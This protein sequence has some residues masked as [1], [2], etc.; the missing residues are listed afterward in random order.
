MIGLKTLKE[1]VRALQHEIDNKRKTLIQ[2]A[3]HTYPL[4]ENIMNATIQNSGS[5]NQ[6]KIMIL[7]SKIFYMSNYMKV[8]PF[9]VQPGKLEIWVNYFASILDSQQDASSSLVA[10]TTSA[11]EIDQLDKQEWWKLKA[12][13]SKISVKL[14]AK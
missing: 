8:L 7:V 12:I 13:C 4:L 10:Q 2:I 5:P 1:L 3:D 14:F 11:D 9:L 6:F